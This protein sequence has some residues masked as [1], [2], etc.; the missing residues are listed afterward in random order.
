[1]AL[2]L[3]I[4]TLD[5]GEHL[6]EHPDQLADLVGRP[7]R[8]PQGVVLAAR[9]VAGP[10]RPAP[11]SARDV[12]LEPRRQQQRDTDRRHHDDG[13]DGDE[14]HQPRAQLGEVGLEIDRADRARRRARSGE[15]PAAAR[16]EHR[17]VGRTAGGVNRGRRRCACRS[18]DVLRRAGTATARADRRLRAQ[19]AQDLGRPIPHRRTPARPQRCDR[20]SPPPRSRSRAWWPGK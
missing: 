13:E 15:R 1:M 17:L 14:A 8:R 9:D 19:P 2:H 16:A 20:R 6:V 12:P 4:A 18:Q 3:A 10:H 11:G 7:R 5:G